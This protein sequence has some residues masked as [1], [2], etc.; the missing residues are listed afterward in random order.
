MF[1]L[2]TVKCQRFY[3]VFAPKCWKGN[4]F[5]VFSHKKVEKALVLLCFRSNMLK[6]HWFYCVFAQ[7]GWKS[8]GFTVFSLK[9]VEKP[10]VLLCFR[11][12]ILKNHWFY[13]KKWVSLVFY[14]TLR[15]QNLI[16][17]VK[18]LVFWSKSCIFSENPCAKMQ[19]TKKSEKTIS[20]YMKN[21]KNEQKTFIFLWF[22]AFLSLADP[23]G[24]APGAGTIAAA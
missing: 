23:F 10:M 7:K 8:I 5:T 6:T 21:C 3:C 20:F 13:F 12:Q 17:L 18:N 9:N 19:K 4:G 11:S 22:F 2:N 16:K 15:S 1:S 14:S 24:Q